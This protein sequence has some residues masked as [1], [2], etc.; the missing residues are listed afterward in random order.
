MRAKPPSSSPSLLKSIGAALA[1]TA[2]ATLSTGAH[3][4]V[5]SADNLGMCFDAEGG[6]REGARVISWP[7]DLTK[8]NQKFWL[9][10]QESVG[11]QRLAIMRIGDFCVRS[12]PQREELIVTKSGCEDYTNRWLVR[13]HDGRYMLGPDTGN[14]ATLTNHVQQGTPIYLTGCR[15]QVTNAADGIV[16]L[17]QYWWV[18]Q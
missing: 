15:T 12:N 7:C 8:P 5:R 1:L 10:W 16:R 13:P 14:C 9:D 6:V 11:F 17:R 4:L 3:A 18:E 2:L